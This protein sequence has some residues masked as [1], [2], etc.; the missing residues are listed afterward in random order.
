[1]KLKEAQEHYYDHSGLASNS[2]RQL[3]FAGIAVVWI[4]AT[5]GDVVPVQSTGLRLPLFAFV[6]T[7][8]LDLLQYYWLALFWGANARYREKRGEEEFSGVS[9]WGNRIGL[10]FF[11]GKGVAVAVGYLPLFSI[12]WP[13]LFQ[14]G[15]GGG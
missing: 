11:W 12:L 7:L 2:A 10:V 13:A 4:L 9:E 1:M 6:A 14:R 8:A 5:N 3:A 15:A